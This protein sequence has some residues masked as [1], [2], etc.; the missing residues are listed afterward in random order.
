MNLIMHLGAVYM[1][2]NC[3]TK[4]DGPVAGMKK[5]FCLYGSELSH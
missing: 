3:P 1:E 2:V 5:K 4:W